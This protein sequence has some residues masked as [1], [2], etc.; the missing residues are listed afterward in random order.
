MPSAGLRLVWRPRS[1]AFAAASAELIRRVVEDLGLAPRLARVEVVV[2]PRPRGD[3]ACIEWSGRGRLRVRLRLDAG[4]FLTAAGR[5]ACAA[6]RTG[7]STLPPRRFSRRALAATLYHEF[8]HVADDVALGIHAG[9][10]E[11]R[12]QPGFNEA[13]NV[14]IDGRLARRGIPGVPRGERWRHFLRAFPPPRHAAAGRPAECGHRREFAALWGAA[15]LSR[16]ALE[17]AA[18]RLGA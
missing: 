12:R 13:W 11:T 14:W 6:R 10:V 17:A 7:M 8:G 3:D 16:S 18:R 4:N 2:R 1:F 5:R 9:G 15:R